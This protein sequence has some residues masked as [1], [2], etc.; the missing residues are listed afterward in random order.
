MQELLSMH[1][2]RDGRRS[3]GICPSFGISSPKD[4][5]AANNCRCDRIPN[6]PMEPDDTAKSYGAI[7]MTSH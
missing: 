6:D 2:E 1:V 4:S 7:S 3:A 5:D